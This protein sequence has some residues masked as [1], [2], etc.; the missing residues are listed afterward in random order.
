MNRIMA[1]CLVVGMLLLPSTALAQNGADL[2]KQSGVQGGVVVHLGCGDGTLT[3]QL[4]VSDRYRVQGLDTDA[5]NVQAA[6][7][8]NWLPPDNTDQ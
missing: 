1:Y 4:L 6:A 2:I 3:Q 7:R 8:I 5:A